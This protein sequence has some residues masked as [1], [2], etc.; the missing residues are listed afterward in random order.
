MILR[1]RAIDFSE[2]FTYII[3]TMIA[4]N[5][6]L[7]YFRY[8]YPNSVEVNTIEEMFSKRQILL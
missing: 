6:I 4:I 5:Q 1:R 8:L 7:N 2:F 3:N